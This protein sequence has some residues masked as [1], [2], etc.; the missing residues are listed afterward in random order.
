MNTPKTQMYC[1]LK[2]KAT[3]ILSKQCQENTKQ[4]RKKKTRNN[5]YD[6]IFE[7]KKIKSHL[8]SLLPRINKSWNACLNMNNVVYLQN[9]M[10][11]GSE[12]KI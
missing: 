5:R 1:M 3:E 7:Y 12:N 9:T 4:K 2:Y 8:W 11:D 10:I 6:I